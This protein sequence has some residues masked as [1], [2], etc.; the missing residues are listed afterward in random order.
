VHHRQAFLL[1]RG[2][3]ARWRIE[4]ETCN[5]LQNQGYH[6]EPNDGQGEQPLSVVLAVLMLLAFWVDQAQQLCWALVQAV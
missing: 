5:T 3:R 4:H 2:G 6:C 1:L